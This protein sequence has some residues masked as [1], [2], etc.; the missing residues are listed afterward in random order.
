[1]RLSKEILLLSFLILATIPVIYHRSSRELDNKISL[2][3]REVQERV[4]NIELLQKF[5]A[6]MPALLGAIQFQSYGQVEIVAKQLMSDERTVKE[7]FI[8]DNNLK[9]LHS[10]VDNY[11]DTSEISSVL[12]SWDRKSNYVV[13]EGDLFVIRKIGESEELGYVIL[14]MDVSDTFETRMGNEEAL[15]IVLRRESAPKNLKRF[16]VEVYEKPR[17]RARYFL[18]FLKDNFMGLILVIVGIVLGFQALMKVLITPFR[19]IVFFLQNLSTGEIR[20]V[21]LEGFPRIFRPYIKYIIEANE[22][23]ISANKRERE[24]EL[25]KAQFSVAQQVAHDIKSPLGLLKS[26]RNDLKNDLSL[27]KWRV[28]QSSL[29][30]I[31]EIALNLLK[32]NP[33]HAVES[34]KKTEDLLPLIEGILV[35]KRTE[36]KKQLN[37]EIEGLFTNDSYGL[38]SDIRPSFLKRIISNL[39]NNSVEACGNDY[40]SVKVGLYPDKKFNC[41]KVVDNGAGIAPEFVESVFK[42][43]FTTKKEGNGLGLSGAKEEIEKMGGKI[44]LDSILGQGTT[45]LIRLPS[46]Q[47]S[48]DVV[49]KIDL[50]RYDKIIVLDDEQ[51]VHDLWDQRLPKTEYMVEHFYS[52]SEFLLKFQNLN[53]K[54]LLLCDFEFE[55]A[56]LNGVEVIG[57]I[58]HGEHSLLVTGRADEDEIIRICEKEGL[59]YLSKTLLPYVNI[60][61][62]PPRIIL[63]DDDRLSHWRWGQHQEKD[64]FLFQGFYSIDSFMAESAEIPKD[65]YILL[66][67]DLGNGIKGEIEGQKIFQLGFSRIYLYTSYPDGPLERPDW[68]VDV[69]GKEPAVVLRRI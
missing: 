60:S 55:G 51:V 65:S 45:V 17:A 16:E 27:D 31:E 24:V 8:L 53:A 69:F 21:K 41:I 25:Q 54:T 20:D 2:S 39:I 59:Q 68:I 48:S 46:S 36:F 49:K 52:P 29:N 34:E 12:A 19:K 11:N 61:V 3:L 28:L 22:R 63:I 33:S 23:I 10:V 6:N 9:M 35:E 50:Y 57:K 26:L 42:K 67:S 14:R 4:K 13:F 58:N 32:K 1:M 38:F 44:E 30:R 18:G 66:D 40:C 64:S 5:M 15:G 56:D 62:Q 47:A 43:G 7:F 37:V